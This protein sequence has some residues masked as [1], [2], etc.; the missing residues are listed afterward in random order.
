MKTH[1]QTDPN[2]RIR[3]EPLPILQED[4]WETESQ[5]SHGEDGEPLILLGKRRTVEHGAVGKAS[6]TLGLQSLFWKQTHG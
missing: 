1:F 6:I 5:R 2:G 4:A 3:D